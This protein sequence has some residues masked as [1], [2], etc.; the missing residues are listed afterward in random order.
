VKKSGKVSI[1]MKN[2][3]K[4]GS[5]KV[6]EMRKYEAEKPRVVVTWSS[7]A[8]Y[9]RA[10]CVPLVIVLCLCHVSRTSIVVTAD[11]WLAD[12]SVAV[13]QDDATTTDTAVCVPVLLL[14]LQ[15]HS[16]ELQ[17]FMIWRWCS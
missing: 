5:H 16:L 2:L 8:M 6:D 7:V 10:S 3:K 4:P 14:S 11:F 12:W 13:P 15:E 1:M 17:N 9:V